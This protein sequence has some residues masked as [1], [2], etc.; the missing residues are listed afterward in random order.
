ME[1]LAEATENHAADLAAGEVALKKKISELIMTLPPP[2]LQEKPHYNR[3][4]LEFA[5]EYGAKEN[6]EDW[7]IHPDGRVM[8]PAVL[9]KDLLKPIHSST[10]L[11]KN[12]MIDLVQK[13][14]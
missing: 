10:H 13:D 5:A 14:F 9:G 6:S 7:M 11:S 12:K 1:N 3:K 8:L 2:M 4:D